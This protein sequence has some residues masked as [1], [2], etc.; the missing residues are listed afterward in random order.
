M[1]VVVVASSTASRERPR[2]DLML[3]PESLWS[4]VRREQHKRSHSQSSGTTDLP[5]GENPAI[6]RIVEEDLHT[7]TVIS[8]HSTT[9]ALY[10]HPHSM[11]AS[12]TVS[13][14]SS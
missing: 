5:R 9:P 4:D 7:T 8:T 3:N 11:H 13:S 1:V 10:P 14:W 12:N 2:A 6:E